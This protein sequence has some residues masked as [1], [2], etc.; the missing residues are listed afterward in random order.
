MANQEDTTIWKNLNINRRFL[1]IKLFYFF[2][3]AAIGDLLPFIP[4]YMKQIGLSSTQTGIVYGIM[5][6]VGFLIRPI[7]GIIADKFQKHK[8]CLILS[9][10]F[11]GV[12]YMLILVIPS[13]TTSYVSVETKISCNE[14]DS[15]IHDCSQ[16]KSAECPLGFENL[17][18]S[19]NKSRHSTN[20]SL[21]VSMYGGQPNSSAAYSIIPSQVTDK[22]YPRLSCSVICKPTTAFPGEVCF[23]DQAELD[24]C[25]GQQTSPANLQFMIYDMLG[26]TRE[27]IADRQLVGNIECHDFAMN[28]VTVGQRR[29]W[30][31]FCH[32]ETEF[33]CHLKCDLG[34]TDQCVTKYAH[35][36]RDKFVL[37]LVIYLFA[38]IAFA[39]VLSMGDAI[40]YDILGDSH[41]GKWGKQRLFGTVGFML[42]ALSSTFIMY[43][44]S[45]SNEEI[46]F[47]VSFYIFGGLC[48][49]SILS[50]WIMPVSGNISSKNMMVH[51]WGV[52]KHPQIVIFLGIVFFFGLYTGAIETFL[53][54]YLEEETIG[55]FQVI[56]G[57]C[58]AIAC[59]AETVLLFVSGAIIK[60]LGHL[61]CIYLVFAAYSL[62][63]LAYSFLDSVFGV[64]PVELLH[65]FTFGIMWATST[66]YASIISP[67]GISATVQGL[68]GGIH[69]GFGKGV[70]S[71]LTGWLYKVVG[72][73][74]AWR[75]YGISSLVLLLIYLIVNKTVFRKPPTELAENQRELDVA[76]HKE[77]KRG[78][79][80]NKI[81]K[82]VN[83]SKPVEQPE[84]EPLVSS[85]G[86]DPAGVETTDKV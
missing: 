8:L 33:N 56:P 68:L 76:L 74:W 30:N 61:N 63:M 67:P 31:M 27:V 55:Y 10:L 75:I 84:S 82:S 11:T 80:Q 53:F 35:V 16:N 78:K 2:T 54:W 86:E 34:I 19:V 41:R 51:I 29:Y 49:L 21:Q 44:I 83:T 52:M 25:L 39:P 43:E 13:D 7:I 85:S 15:Y 26:S 79:D 50:V 73:R 45:S 64:L 9:I 18:L 37:F 28:N 12:F 6:F 70:G 48:V 69:F 5:P 72:I 65:G 38:N 60:R 22:S 66:S 14:Y 81:D 47:S 32:H 1:P 77:R 3:T 40:A 42:F 17:L 71:L 23:T 46:D 58:L 62:R 4:L 36:M 57:F 59:L 24:Q 20:S